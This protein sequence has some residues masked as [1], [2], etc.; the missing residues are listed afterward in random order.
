MKIFQN[1]RSGTSVVAIATLT[2]SLAFSFS[3][4]SM[5][6]QDD[7]GVS[8]GQ[9]P[10]NLIDQVTDS[11]VAGQDG[12]DNQTT[13]ND[14]IDLISPDGGKSNDLSSVDEKADNQSD[15]AQNS[16]SDAADTG[17]TIA[18]TTT[19]GASVTLGRRSVSDVGLA[20]IGVA[21]QDVSQTTLDSLIW[22]GTSATQANQLL[23]ADA[24]N[25][26]SRILSNLAHQVVARQSVP[27]TGAN[28][29]ARDLVNARLSWLAKAG[30]SNELAVFVQQ[31]PEDE[32]WLDWKKW[33]VQH[34]L[35]MLE[36][37][38][39]CRTVNDQATQTFEPF[40]HQTKVICLIVAGD[41]SGAQFS[42]DI[43][44]ASGSDDA[45]FFALVN[46]MLMGTPAADLDPAMFE[47][48]HIVLMDAAHHE[49]PLEGLAAL[50]TRM[51]Q[52]AIGLRYLSADA[53]MVSTF[54]AMALGLIDAQKTAKLW[55]NIAVNAD[56]AE[57]ALARHGSQPS[58]LTRSM[59]WRALDA[60]KSASRLPLIAAAMDIDRADGHAHVMI[61]LYAELV[62]M[63]MGF[64]GIET[65]LREDQSGAAGKIALL[66]ALDDAQATGL[67]DTFP[68]FTYAD[69]AAKLLDSLDEPSWRNMLL[70][71][72]N[73]WHLM[74]IL[75]AIG[76]VPDS[77]D[78]LELMP[79]E[80]TYDANAA[81]VPNAQTTS[82][83]PVMLR[84]I[85]QAAEKRRVAETI[86]LANRLLISTPLATINTND[87]AVVIASLNDVGQ[88]VVAKGV[89]REIITAHLLANTG[90][91]DMTAATGNWIL[92]KPTLDAGDDA[93]S[94]GN[95]SEA[96]S[97]VQQDNT[98]G[99]DNANDDM[100]QNAVNFD[101][102][103]QNDAPAK[104]DNS[105]EPDNGTTTE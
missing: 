90:G 38:D 69:S 85:Q 58:A 54:N 6:Q 96:T 62:R 80:A 93:Q 95:V 31:L 15:I 60:E 41:L 19:T 35:M 18:N 11:D 17:A 84:A 86:L 66:L 22:R 87:V 55:R 37:D 48:L 32:E 91:A 40:W 76:M 26:R 53:R 21:E 61:S 4:S 8:G 52:S 75:E 94:N 2:F 28:A 46:E 50:P 30:R 73:Q 33:L 79:L 82:L 92:P 105:T 1:R 13:L 5:A 104:P 65:A 44:K 88:T 83:S 25:S 56:S 7:S 29:N 81:T 70:R 103:A 63:A 72:L 43:L 77:T 10:L 34:R 42:A 67:P 27:P 20:A 59:V 57:L 99:S 74:P 68:A 78:W 100:T 98:S 16:V 36:D 45:I 3:A 97:F 9:Q 102:A 12:R 101:S 47:P 49:I 89:A 39:A 23:R 51:A 64:D 24:V 14:A 71:D